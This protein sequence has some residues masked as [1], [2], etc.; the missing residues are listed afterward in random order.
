MHI[1]KLDDKGN[2]VKPWLNSEK[3]VSSNSSVRVIK[4]NRN[5]NFLSRLFT[6][7]YYSKIVDAWVEDSDGVYR[8]GVTEEYDGLFSGK[9]R[10]NTY[11]MYC[12]PGGDDYAWYTSDFNEA[13]DKCLQVLW[14]NR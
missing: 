3:A 11:Y 1:I 4:S 10:K 8:I 7:K 2:Q 14:R 12:F 6:R 13:Y 9:T 5:N